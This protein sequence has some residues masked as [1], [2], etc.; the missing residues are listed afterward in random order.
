MELLVAT[1]VA[2]VLA[3]SVMAAATRLYE[4][5]EVNRFN[6]RLSDW[7]LN[8]ENLFLVRSDYQNLS[9][10]A[11]VNLGLLDDE[12]MNIDGNTTSPSTVLNV[13]HLYGGAIEIGLPT[14]MP[15]QFWAVHLGGLPAGRR[16][17]TLL[18][19]AVNVGSVVA[20]I[21]E[22]ANGPSNLNHWLGGVTYSG[23]LNQVS[24]FPANYKILRQ[25]DGTLQPVT[26]LIGFCDTNGMHAMGLALIRKKM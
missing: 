6:Q 16:C 1:S 23:A 26:D 20:V 10:Q 22:S 25:T 15:G 24:G 7:V 5:H 9:L 8:V 2:G 18:Q 3:L 14:Q 4:D 11:V 21:D 17:V 12:V 19:H 13:W